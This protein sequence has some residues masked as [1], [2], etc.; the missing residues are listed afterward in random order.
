MGAQPRLFG[1]VDADI[2]TDLTFQR[3]VHRL[4]QLGDRVLG[5]FLAELGAERSIQTL[6]DMK[7]ARYAALTSEQLRATGGDRFPPTP[8][9]QV[10]P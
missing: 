4:H 10:R 9:R 7:V 3:H 5:E 2:M 6:I 1:P 8:I